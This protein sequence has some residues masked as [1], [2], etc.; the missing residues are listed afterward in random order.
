MTSPSKVF[1]MRF[2]S[3]V[4]ETTTR[5]NAKCAMCYQSVGP[6]GSDNWGIHELKRDTLMRVIDDA[7]HIPN[8]HKRLHISGGE[9]FLDTKLVIAL[10]SRGRDVGYDEITLTTNAYWGKSPEAADKICRQLLDCG[11]TDMEI[12]W[13]YWHTDYI[14]AERVVN[15]LRAA[16]KHSVK[17]TLRVLTSKSH[18]A[19]EALSLLGEGWKEADS[20][21]WG[22][23]FGTGRAATKLGPAELHPET[24]APGETCHNFLNLTVNAKGDVF[25]CCAGLDQTDHVGLG[26]VHEEPISRIAERMSNNLWLR[27]LVFE[28]VVAIEEVVKESGYAFEP[29]ENTG[30]CTRCWS[31]FRDQGATEI[32]KAHGRKIGRE[33][34]ERALRRPRAA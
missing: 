16:R 19:G 7:I 1:P 15:V 12:S 32:V 5:C 18:S 34:V 23:V 33:I 4:I 29:E 26:Q 25:P 31:V 30:M 14:K 22:K 17:T 3:L 28:G 10:L 24:L 20:V 9:A 8:L 13:D 11:V 27:K 21:M 2:N 6:K